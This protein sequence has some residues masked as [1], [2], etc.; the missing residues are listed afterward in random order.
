MFSA[1]SG[2]GRL[3][4]AAS[5]PFQS[6][7]ARSPRSF[8]SNIEESVTYDL[9]FPDTDNLQDAQHN[10]HAHRHEQGSLGTIARSTDDRE[11][12]GIHTSRDVRLLIAQKSLD[13]HRIL[14]DSHPPSAYA[15]SRTSPPLSSDTNGFV[16]DGRTVN[17]LGGFRR[18]QKARTAPHSRNGSLSQTPNG[19][20]SNTNP[21]LSSVTENGGL[22]GTSRSQTQTA[23]PKTS[24]GDHIKAKIARE[25][26]EETDDI[27]G[28]MFGPSESAATSATKVHSKPYTDKG[29]GFNRPGSAESR[30]MRSPQH[31]DSRRSLLFRSTTA[32]NLV[33][34]AC[35]AE[36]MTEGQLSRRTS[37]YILVTR[38]FTL[39]LKEEDLNNACAPK[40]GDSTAREQN[41]DTHT[42]HTRVVESRSSSRQIKTPV[43]AV[44]LV[45]YVPLRSSVLRTFGSGRTQSLYGGSHFQ[46]D[47]LKYQLDEMLDRTMNRLPLIIRALSSLETVA[48]AQIKDIILHQ[49][50]GTIAS[51]RRAFQVV[52]NALQHER[53]VHE[54]ARLV[55]K[56]VTAGLQIRSVIAG[57]NRWSL[58]RSVARGLPPTSTQHESIGFLAKILTAFLAFHSEWLGQHAPRPYRY[59]KIPH[60]EADNADVIRIRTVIVCPD[61]LMAR[62]FIFLLAQF[63]PRNFDLTFQQPALSDTVSSSIGKSKSPYW[64][65]THEVEGQEHLEPQ[66][67]TSDAADF[68][69]PDANRSPIA[70]SHHRRASDALSIRSLAM[71]IVNT[72]SRK[73]SVTTTATMQP[74]LQQIV[75]HFSPYSPESVVSPERP[76]SSGSL[77]ALSLQRSLSRTES[78]EPGS[79]E[80]KGN[81]AWGS[82]RSG[83]WSTRR[84]SSTETSEMVS[85]SGEGLAITVPA[86]MRQ[87]SSSP[88]KLGRMLKDDLES[89]GSAIYGTASSVG[90]LTSPSKFAKRPVSRSL[91]DFSPGEDT[92][93]SLSFDRKSG[94][95]D[96]QLSSSFEES[97]SRS[98]N[99]DRSFNRASSRGSNTSNFV[100]SAPVFRPQAKG[101]SIAGYLHSF[102]PDFAVQAVRP[103]DSLKQEIKTAMQT[104]QRSLPHGDSTNRGNVLAAERDSPSADD[105]A[106][107]SEAEPSLRTLLIN[108]STFTLT[109]L[110]WTRPVAN[111]AS[112]DVWSEEDMTSLPANSELVN[113]LQRIL[114]LSSPA[115]PSRS[116]SPKQEQHGSSDSAH[117]MNPPLDRLPTSK[118]H[119]N[120]ILGTLTLLAKDIADEIDLEQTYAAG[121]GVGIQLNGTTR[122]RESLKDAKVEY[123]RTSQEGSAMGKADEGVSD[124]NDKGEEPPAGVTDGENEAETKN[125]RGAGEEEAQQGKVEKED[126][127]RTSIR[128]WMENLREQF[129]GRGKDD[130]RSW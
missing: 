101:P 42:R 122:H 64:Q 44:G 81:D 18:I 16:K 25:E 6:V 127:L 120:S 124:A 104:E 112:Q 27:L 58:W 75:P 66:L 35:E 126:I 39:P 57:Q 49:Y 40:M 78:N 71:P 88:G 21:P 113:T 50:D 76:T 46:A 95:V 86:F 68:A 102:H 103:T 15:P 61:K 125:H 108:P 52:P 82:L 89:N 115:Q 2:L 8:D 83:F 54:S 7:S 5:A 13:S 110:A 14:Y 37:S 87:K 96:V 1:T 36:A 22:F 111:D 97:P 118:D 56:R 74:D 105:T 41:L 117:T 70:P 67:N 91:P 11:E 106:N 84:G 62:R 9:L 30:Q 90:T 45:I 119:R 26:K 48:D 85:S 69:N 80:S 123:A 79:L 98:Q 109:C 73:S 53:G 77:A 129:E 43:F 51:L 10:I 24:E 94:V 130:E 65:S 34:Q 107:D 100:H 55:S 17:G 19:L 92:P 3:F 12:L 33:A 59:W 116:S 28:C 47:M 38:L 63:M 60:L 23:R 121:K 128:R 114:N 93:L 29:H 4:S 20:F 31:G 72:A 32:E 99:P